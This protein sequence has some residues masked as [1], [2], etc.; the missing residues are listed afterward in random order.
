MKSR[1]RRKEQYQVLLLSASP[2]C[3]NTMASLANSNDTD[4]RTKSFFLLFTCVF[5]PSLPRSRSE[6][7]LETL[8]NRAKIHPLN[9]T[10]EKC[11]NKLQ[12]V[13]E[14]LVQYNIGETSL[15]ASGST[16]L[17]PRRSLLIYWSGKSSDSVRDSEWQWLLPYGS[18]HLLE[19]M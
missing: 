2:Y 17:I 14:Q 15:L 1:W 12:S 9:T 8:P 18:L 7:R 13:K 16:R 19:V 6:S 3:P 10:R 4:A 5:N 11:D